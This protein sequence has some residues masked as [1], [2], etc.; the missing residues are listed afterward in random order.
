MT[1]T[2]Y[3]ATSISGQAHLARTPFV[4]NIDVSQDRRYAASPVDGAQEDDGQISCFCGFSDDDGNTVGCDGCNRW[5]HIICYYPEYEGR[6]LPD[7]LQ[8][9]CIECRPRQVDRYQANYRQRL[10]RD[11]QDGHVDG[12]KR[13]AAKSHKKKVREPAGAGTINGWPTDKFRHD[14]TSASPRDQPPPAKRPKTSHR[15]S[16]SVVNGLNKGHARKRTGVNANQP[17]SQSQ[18]PEATI[19]MYSPEFY[20][21]YFD[22]EW[23]VTRANLHNDIGVT[24]ALSEWLRAP[25]DVFREMHGLEKS[26]VL[27]RWDGE[28]DDIPGKA[29]LYITSAQDETV[30]DSHGQ[31]PTRKT[32]T[33]QEPVAS[34]AYIGELKGHVG[35]KEEYKHDPVNRWA[36]LRHPEPFV[37]FHPRLPIY[38]DARHEGTALRYVRRSCMPNAE[39]RVLVTDSTDYRFCFMATDQIDPG[40]EIAV[41]WDTSESVPGKLQ[42]QN[43]SLSTRDMD[44]L[45]AWVST[46]LSNCGPCACNQSPADCAMSRF[47]KRGVALGYDEEAQPVKLPKGRK[48]KVGQHVSSSNTTALNSRSGSEVRK[49]EPDDERTD[50]RSTSRSGGRGSVSRDITPNTHYSTNGS[51]TVP[52]LS[53]RERKKLEKEEEMFRRQEEEQTGKAKKKRNSAGS[54][55]N[56]PNPG[57]SKQL[58][59]GAPRYVDAATARQVNLPT[60]RSA[61]N[62]GKRPKGAPARKGPPKVVYKTVPRPKAEVKDS[63]V[64]CDMDADETQARLSTPTLPPRKFVSNQQR[65]LNRLAVRNAQLES[66]RAEAKTTKGA[67]IS[68]KEGAE[69]SSPNRPSSPRSDSSTFQ[70]IDSEPRSSPKSSGDVSMESAPEEE[71]VAPDELPKHHGQK[72]PDEE[73][74]APADGD[75]LV[76][77]PTE[78]AAPPWPPTLNAPMDS[79]SAAAHTQRVPELHMSMPPPPSNPFDSATLLSAGSGN[80][81]A[82]SPSGF[83]GSTPLLSPS[84]SAAVMP[85][86]V[87]TKKMSLS[88]Y[89][90]RHKPKDRPFGDGKGDRES[91]PASVAS[92]AGASGLHPTSSE[93][94][95]AGDNVSAI[96]EEDVKMEDAT[97]HKS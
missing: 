81:A 15:A 18:S 45:S 26:Q 47:D 42:N 5:N 69:A 3:P 34:G 73:R 36:Q 68:A 49:V 55:L 95:K 79:P 4:N 37:F 66:E 97:S 17:R 14:R 25:D 74:P 40:M 64:Q 38:V 82:Q 53:A 19:Q 58:G 21:C 89:T 28:L 30:S 20:R 12:A 67:S 39:L 9:F 85:S 84:V 13:P 62:G 60:A 59:F 43:S 72:P 51:S 87:K 32:V 57:T 92:G 46:V 44:A 1:D 75:E 50:S 22:D 71:A 65:L 33:V 91:S 54:A 11:Q 24:N 8:H 94:Q 61:G 63:G 78:T 23:N 6:D 90:R 10:K 29:Q 35:F 77:V 48:K 56:T 80:T 7:D 41:S 88:D 93:D 52:E 16:E 76:R 70:N 96:A 31:H 27:M 2:F 83:S 86:P